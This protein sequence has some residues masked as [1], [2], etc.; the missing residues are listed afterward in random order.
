M[1]HYVPK[2]RVPVT[3][4]SRDLP[5]LA[6]SIF[7]DLDAAG[8]QHQTILERMNEST[9]FLPVAVGPEGRI[10]LINKARLARL[11]VGKGVVPGDVFARGFQPW[12]EEHV[13]VLLADGTTLAGRVWMPLERATQRISDFMNQR[14]SEFFALITSV[15]VHLVNAASVVNIQVSEKAGASLAEEEGDRAVA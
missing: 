14:G 13:Q 2:R 15:T 9:R 3:L 6:G 5:G 10:H 12:R 1:D 8:N 7:L 11:T 4:W